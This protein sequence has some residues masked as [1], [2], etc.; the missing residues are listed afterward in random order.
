MRRRGLFHRCNTI[1]ISGCRLLHGISIND[2]SP[3]H[4]SI[5]RNSDVTHNKKN[6][7]PYFLTVFLQTDFESTFFIQNIIPP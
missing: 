6:N 2:L 4:H 7:H 1:G 3:K 5:L